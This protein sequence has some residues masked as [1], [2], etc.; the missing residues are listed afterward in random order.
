[1]VVK[2]VQLSRT[3]SQK[4]A[5]KTR[6]QL[7]DATLNVF[8]E[9][10]VDAAT[11]E[12]I[13]QR[14]NLGK[15]TLYRHFGDKYEIVI[16]LAEQTVRRLAERFISY[17]REPDNL[18]DVLEHE[19]AGELEKSYSY[20]LGEIENHVSPYVSWKIDPVKIR[21]LVCAV[22]GF[23][24]GI[25]SFAMIGMTSEKIETSIE[26]LRRAFVRSLSAFLERQD[27]RERFVNVY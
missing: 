18:E 15:G 4:R 27:E 12:E 19:T 25:F 24:F 3:R 20:Y 21:R 2:S 5:A 11:V 14:A 10:G 6:Q 17:D 26:P 8:S 7:Q 9:R 13:T 16:T 22:A 23:V 1:M